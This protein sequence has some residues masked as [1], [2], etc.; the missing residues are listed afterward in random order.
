MT[1]ATGYLGLE[2]KQ[3]WTS[4]YLILATKLISFIMDTLN[5]FGGEVLSLASI[6]NG[7]LYTKSTL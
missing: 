6:I 1:A 4:L 7:D 3:E 2:P 5:V